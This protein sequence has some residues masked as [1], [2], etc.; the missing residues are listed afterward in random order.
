MKLKSF[1]VCV[2]MFGMLLLIQYTSDDHSLEDYK[3]AHNSEQTK[4]PPTNSN[5]DLKELETGLAY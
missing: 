2:S 4:A 5:L 3:R 1:L